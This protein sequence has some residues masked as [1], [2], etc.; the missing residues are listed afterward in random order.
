MKDNTLN[1][2]SQVEKRTKLVIEQMFID[3]KKL[4]NEGKHFLKNHETVFTII[5]KNLCLL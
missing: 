5:F 3:H 2:K 4:T 1:K